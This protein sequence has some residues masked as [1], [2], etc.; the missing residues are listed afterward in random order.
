MKLTKLNKMARTC[1]LTATLILMGASIVTITAT[2]IPTGKG[3]AKFL[4]KPAAPSAASVPASMTCAKCV[5]VYTTT[6]DLSA[7]GAN[8]PNTFVARHGCG[9]CSTL[10]TTVGFGKAKQNVAL[11]T[12]ASGAVQNANCCARN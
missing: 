9:G 8:K 12:C 4:M 2:D 6:R 7:R 3:A 5:D 11:H 10:I 1:G